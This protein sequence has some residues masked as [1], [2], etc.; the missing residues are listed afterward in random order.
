MNLQRKC[1]GVYYAPGDRY[2]STKFEFFLQSPGEIVLLLLSGFRIFSVFYDYPEL[3]E[4]RLG[5]VYDS[6]EEIKQ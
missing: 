2:D 5:S 3:Q 4:V 1:N 6:V